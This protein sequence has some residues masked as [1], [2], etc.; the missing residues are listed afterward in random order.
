MHVRTESVTPFLIHSQKWG[1]HKSIRESGLTP[2]AISEGIASRLEANINDGEFGFSPE[3]QKFLFDVLL[4][5]I[6]SVE[7]LRNNFKRAQAA[8]MAASVGKSIDPNYAPSFS[9]ELQAL[10]SPQLPDG[11][12]LLG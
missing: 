5:R 12:S 4:P 8:V 9:V 3:E 11:T 7:H 6:L 10:V 1:L 2:T